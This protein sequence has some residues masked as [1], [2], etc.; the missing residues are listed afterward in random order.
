MLL[1]EQLRDDRGVRALIVVDDRDDKMLARRFG[2]PYRDTPQ[3]IVEMVVGGALAE[4]DGER[5]WRACF[6]DRGRWAGCRVALA[7]AR[8]GAAKHKE[9]EA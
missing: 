8:S 1:A 4:A 3:L 7:E 2:L 5:V 9:T 6:S